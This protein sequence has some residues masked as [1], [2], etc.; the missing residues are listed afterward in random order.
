MNYKKVKANKKCAELNLTLKIKCEECC[1]TSFSFQRKGEDL[2][3]PFSTETYGVL[4]INCNNCGFKYSFN[5][6]IDNVEKNSI[7]T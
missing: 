3:T 1:S 2:D 6:K 7:F 4:G 5:L